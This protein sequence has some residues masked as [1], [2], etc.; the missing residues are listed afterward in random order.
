MKENVMKST[1]AAVLLVFA[2]LGSAYAQ[3]QMS[4]AEL[5]EAN[6]QIDDATK[7]TMEKDADADEMNK[8]I[9]NY[10][11]EHPTAKA[12]EAMEMALYQ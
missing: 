12:S 3:A 11:A 7:A 10:C 4:C 6:K 2:S 8:K 1:L 9:N 5:L